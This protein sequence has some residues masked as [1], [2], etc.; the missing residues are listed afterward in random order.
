MAATS[1]FLLF[2]REKGASSCQEQLDEFRKLVGSVQK[3]VKETEGI[4]P[5][6][7]MSLGSHELEKRVQQIEVRGGNW[8]GVL[9]LAL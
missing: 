4:I 1:F 6:T 9:E 3:W 7:E 2:I 5:T 8:E